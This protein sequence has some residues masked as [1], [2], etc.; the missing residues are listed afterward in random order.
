M[1]AAALLHASVRPRLATTPLRFANP[2]PPSGWIEDSHLLAVDHARHTKTGKKHRLLPRMDRPER[3][4]IL[5]NRRLRY[6]FQRRRRREGGPIRDVGE[7]VGPGEVGGDH[8]VAR[9]TTF[10]L[11]GSQNFGQQDRI[12]R[13]RMQ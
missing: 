7:A 11:S 12:R 5:F 3:I 8:H 10:H 2:S 4:R 1:R 9:E 13:A 6:Y